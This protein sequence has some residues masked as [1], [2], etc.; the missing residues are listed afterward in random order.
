MG[1]SKRFFEV[2]HAHVVT[3]MLSPWKK[4][5]GRALLVRSRWSRWPTKFSVERWWLKNW[6]VGDTSNPIIG[7]HDTCQDIGLMIAGYC[8]LWALGFILDFKVGDMWNSWNSDLMENCKATMSR[9]EWRH[10]DSRHEIP[11]RALCLWS[12]HKFRNSLNS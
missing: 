6:E 8:R 2:L 7:I 3:I 12:F 4:T 5:A 1:N 10:T 11:L 9:K